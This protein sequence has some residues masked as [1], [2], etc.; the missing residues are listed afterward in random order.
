MKLPLSKWAMSV[1]TLKIDGAAKGTKKGRV[2]S[3]RM[4]WSH[5]KINIIITHAD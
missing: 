2:I 5:G 1:A 3:V 4:L